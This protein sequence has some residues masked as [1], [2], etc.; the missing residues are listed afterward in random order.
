M[1]T[2]PSEKMRRQIVVPDKNLICPLGLIQIT[3]S[4][5]FILNG[6]GEDIKERDVRFSFILAMA[7]VCL[8]MPFSLL[9]AQGNDTTANTVTRNADARKTGEQTGQDQE[10]TMNP[11]VVSATR[12]EVPLS[13][14]TKS[15]GVVERKDFTT[16]Q[17]SFIPEALDT[18]PGVLF[19]ASGG[20][21]QYANIDIRGA[22]P[23]H[24][25]FQFNGFPLKDA[26][27]T[28][29]ALQ[30]FTEDLFGGTGIDRVEVLKGS[31]STLHGSSAMGGV[32]NIIPQ[33]WHQGIL[34][35]VRHEMGENNTF[36]ESGSFGYGQKNFY[37]NFNPIYVDTDG[38]RG[39]WYNNLGFTGSA[40]FKF[41]KDMT[42]EVSNASSVSDLALSASSPSLDANHNLIPQVVSSTDHRES[43]MNL[44]T[45]TLN[46]RVSPMWNYAIRGAYGSTERHYFWSDTPGNQSNYDGSTTFIDMQHNIRPV[47]WLLLTVGADYDGSNYDG[48]EPLDPSAGIYDPQYFKYS[49]YAYN[50]FGQA[51]ATFFDKS[52]FLTG[53]LRYNDHEEFDSKVVGEASAA[54][55]FKQTGT[56]IHSAF[57]TGYRTPSLYEIYG[58]YLYNGQLITIGN[59]D[60]KPEESTS[61]EAGISQPFFDNRLTLG[62]TWFHLDFENLIDF[63]GFNMRYVNA[64]E[65][66]SEGIEVSAEMKP[67]KYIS[68]LVAFTHV[69]AK[70]R[71]SESQEWTRRNYW[72]ENTI[73]FLTT[74]H[75]TDRLSLACKVTW[76]DEKTIPL[77]DPSY[78]QVLWQEPGAARVDLAATY[79]LVKNHDTLRNIDIFM[80]V[81]NLLDEY[82]TES[83]N[84]MPGRTIYGGV[85]FAF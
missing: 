37:M 28:Q 72:P 55:I 63:D 27:D 73:S 68:F 11:V 65:G 41:G 9:Q 46:Q 79:K 8:A 33:K 31:N 71:D 29:S 67:C 38:D 24:V 13:E 25:Q 53:G 36:I 82:Y 43:Q 14:L 4:P 21:G 23:Q 61:Y 66:K 76:D 32:I 5:V 12:T 58:G 60:L 57:G 78:N 6:G 83:G 40:G 1:A 16:Q 42:L 54:Y 81:Q 48:R 49:W 22:G 30:Y 56:K 26:A 47:E 85:K 59:P 44:T 20:I 62:F 64:S 74:V 3:L 84:I 52:L 50:V 17:Q 2:V 39:F 18:I 45:L 77:Y 80:K 51:Q 75:P 35:E 70:A 10:Y 19:Q 69:D 34:G 15:V 7:I